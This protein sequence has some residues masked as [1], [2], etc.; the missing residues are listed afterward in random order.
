MMVPTQHKV[1][2]VA[3][4]CAAMRRYFVCWSACETL[5]HRWRSSC[6]ASK[7]MSFKLSFSTA[8]RLPIETRV[9][10][11]TAHMH[12]SSSLTLFTEGKCETEG[13]CF[14]SVITYH[15]L[16]KRGS[17][18]FLLDASI[19]RRFLIHGGAS[20]TRGSEGWVLVG[21]DFW[22]DPR[23]RFLVFV[24]FRQRQNQRHWFLQV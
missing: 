24:G 11:R 19:D 1:Q 2:R 7:F 3:D 6:H 15:T 8:W 12:R 10:N 23:P 21:E 4:L 16:W 17:F 14:L 18:L 13:F 9:T 5:K 20:R 22:E